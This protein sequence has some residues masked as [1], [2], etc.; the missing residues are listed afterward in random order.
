ML[1]N[2]QQILDISQKRLWGLEKG[3]NILKSWYPELPKIIDQILVSKDE[4]LFPN[5]YESPTGYRNYNSNWARWPFSNEEWQSCI[6]N[7]HYAFP[8]IYRDR[9]EITLAIETSRLI[10][11]SILNSMWYKNIVQK[12]EDLWELN[13]NNYLWTH[14]YRWLNN[15]NWYDIWDEAFNDKGNLHSTYQSWVD[16]RILQIAYSIEEKKHENSIR[17]LIWDPIKAIH[18]DLKNKI[19]AWETFEN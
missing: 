15:I 12:V 2:N 18:D 11:M 9:E 16:K 4:K 7:R 13:K 3:I 5:G 19:A 17:K 6:L 1:L 14:R 8:N 10:Q